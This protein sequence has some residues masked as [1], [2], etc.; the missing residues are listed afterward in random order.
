LRPNEIWLPVLIEGDVAIDS[1][2]YSMIDGIVLRADVLTQQLLPEVLNALILIPSLYKNII[3]SHY[4]DSIQLPGK[5][6]G[7]IWVRECSK[8]NLGGSGVFS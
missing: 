3:F 7:V 6:L 4:C 2:Y 1:F 8:L 5:V